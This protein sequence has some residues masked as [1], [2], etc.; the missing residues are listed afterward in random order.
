MHR[1]LF[2]K[3]LNSSRTY[4]WRFSQGPSFP[5]SYS[6]EGMYW[7]GPALKGW[8]LGSRKD[9]DG[10]SP[11]SR[12]TIYVVLVVHYLTLRDA[13]HLSSHM[14]G[15]SWNGV[16][17]TEWLKSA[18]LHILKHLS[19]CQFNQNP[20]TL[21]LWGIR[22]IHLKERKTITPFA[23]LF[24]PSLSVHP[25]TYCDFHGTNFRTERE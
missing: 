17:R 19:P 23:C 11:S 15:T 25:L 16:L 2:N 14:F 18:I 5:M 1:P 21:S 3:L 6:L 12:T 7:C 10:H 22:S 8:C 13:N 20:S 4:I 24:H 9:S